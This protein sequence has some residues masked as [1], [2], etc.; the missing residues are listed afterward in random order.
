[1]VT[2][3]KKVDGRRKIVTHA[4]GRPPS[5]TDEVQEQIFVNRRL[6]ISWERSARLAGVNI[7][8]VKNWKARGEAAL[9]KTPTKR[10]AFDNK[11]IAFLAASAVVEDEWLRRCET[12]LA[13]ALESGSGKERWN[14]ASDAD[15]ALATSTAKFKLTHQASDEYSTKSA[16]ELTGKD[17]G[18]VDI[19]LSGED[20]F[21]VLL[22]AKA[23]EEASEE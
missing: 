6:G 9:E 10:N 4:G 23:V 11:C 1:M 19:A 7:T 16:T 2:P 20:V 14:N 21:K 3:K 5:L 13:F 12:V 18:P 22:E 8:T 17:G 15:R